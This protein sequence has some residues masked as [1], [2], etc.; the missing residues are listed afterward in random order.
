MAE[1]VNTIKILKARGGQEITLD[2]DQDFTIGELETLFDAGLME[3]GKVNLDMDSNPKGLVV[4]FHIYANRGDAEVSE[5]E[6]RKI[7]ISSMTGLFDEINEKSDG[8]EA[9]GGS[10]T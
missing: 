7:P 1:K 10:P 2:I 8:D 3:G 9:T 6:I 4:L 5:D